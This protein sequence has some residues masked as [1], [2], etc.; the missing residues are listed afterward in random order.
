M[1]RRRGT[2]LSLLVFASLLLGTPGAH[3]APVTVTNGSQFTDTAGALVH[4]H[5]GGLLKVGAYYY[6]FGENRNADDTFR[7]VSA[8]RSADLKTWEFRGDVLT[9]SSASELGRAKIERPKVIYN[10]ATG[11]YVMWMHKEN[12][13]DYAE[14]R[15]AV[16]TSPTVDGGYTYRGSFR[17]L[18]VHMSRDIT[19][20]QDDD[21]TA[22]MASA[23]R[24][25]ADLNVYRLSTDYTGVSALVQTLWPGSYREAPALF[26][27]NGV[28]FMVTSA[29]T[30]WQPN[31]QKYATATS[32][33][34]T[35]SG[36]ANV[37]DA[38]GY[39]SQ[40]AYVLPVQGSQA[41]SYLYLGDRWAGAWSR[42]VTESR[43]V[44]L[45]LAF[46]SATTLS[47]TWSP[48][49]SVDVATG[50]VAGVGSGSAYESLV[51]RHSGKCADIPGSSRTDGTQLTQYSCNNG[52][53]QQW[54]VLDLGNGYVNLIARHSG[55][56]LDVSG[57]STADGAAVVQWPCGGGANQQW[58]LQ[59]ADGGYVRISA[60]H[61]GK[62]LDVV[63]ASTAD[64][65]AV[66]QYPCTGVTNQQWQQ[67]AA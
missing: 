17:P 51:A 40:T 34:G 13:D 44:W 24:E 33:T 20:F 8:Y 53:N 58:Q 18:G 42:P 37:G 39:G 45:P 1:L 5:G 6:W 21:G 61:S 7:A 3:A 35:W 52:G 50:V 46:P 67:R 22:Y 4:A 63:S 14:A 16:A 43:Y 9:Q 19:L 62:C 26:K 60:R 28:Y 15:A 25:N 56:C 47:M 55:Q 38:T 27:R 57:A 2:V 59:A 32:I 36:L 10:R 65:A 49:V 41:T 64:G 54:S 11:Q 23:A 31:Q 29:A 48:K 66:K 30:G 12:G